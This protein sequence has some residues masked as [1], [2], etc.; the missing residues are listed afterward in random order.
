[1]SYKWKPS[2]SA[3]REFA[4]KMQ[5]IETFCRENGIDKSASGDSYY[6]EI[7][8]QKYR[9]AITRLRR[10]MPPHITTLVNR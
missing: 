8:G 9:S 7:N 1:M 4:A 5:E 3:A 2:K 6:F 10:V